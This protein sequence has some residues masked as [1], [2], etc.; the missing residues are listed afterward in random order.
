MRSVVREYDKIGKRNKKKD[1]NHLNKHGMHLIRLFMM[2]MDI[3]EK[4]QILTHRRDDLPLLLSIRRG[5]YMLPDGTFSTAFYE[6]LE[7]Y[8][9]RFDEAAQKTTLPDN[10]DMNAVEKFVERVNLFAVTGELK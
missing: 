7:E 3:L 4:G 5:D 9:R 8:E 6:L 2:G 10:P 1:E